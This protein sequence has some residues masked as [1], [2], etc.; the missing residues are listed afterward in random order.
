MTNEDKLKELEAVRALH[1]HPD[2]VLWLINRVKVLTEAL[3]DLH[4]TLNARTQIERVNKAL[5]DTG[6]KL[7][8][9][10]NF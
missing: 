5:N 7:D 6:Y 9:K 3:E 8:E 4:P 1:V 10:N 2:D